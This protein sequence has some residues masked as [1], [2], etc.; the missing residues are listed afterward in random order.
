M[1]TAIVALQHL[2]LRS[3]VTV[4][5]DALVGGTTA[6]LRAGEHIRVR[7]LFYGMMLPSGNDAAVTLADA[8]AGSSS[9]FAGLMNREARHLHLWHSH[10]VVPHG[11]DTVGQYSSARD[12][13]RLAHELLKHP[14]LAHVVRTRVYKTRSADGVYSHRWSNL[15][16][17]LGEYPGAIGIKTGTTPLAGANL[18]AAA[19]LHG[20]RIIVVLLGDTESGR[21]PDATRLLNYGWRLLGYQV[22]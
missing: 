16:L 22:P 20:H 21:F 14:F 7:D 12:L 5:P 1:L 13:A 18:V 3:I 2:R 9:R 6:N 17:L 11:M 19:T 15:N 10:F 4:R 8:A